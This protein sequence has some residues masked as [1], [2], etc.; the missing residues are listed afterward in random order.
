MECCHFRE[1]LVPCCTVGGFILDPSMTEKYCRNADHEECSFRTGV[2]DPRSSNQ[3]L[4][5]DRNALTLT[6]DLH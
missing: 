6:A 1:W 4:P 5:I 2:S 3:F